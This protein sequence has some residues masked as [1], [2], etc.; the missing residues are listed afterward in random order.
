MID[1]RASEQARGLSLIDRIGVIDGLANHLGSRRFL[2][3][4]PAYARRHV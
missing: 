2:P 3:V 4:Q 1:S